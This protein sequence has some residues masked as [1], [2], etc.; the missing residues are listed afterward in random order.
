MAEVK[1]LV[2]GY[3]GKE[4]DGRTCPTITLIQDKGLNIIVDPGSVANQ[5][6]LIDSLEKIGLTVGDID[7][8][9]L[10]HSHIDHYMNVSLFTNAKY[11]EYFGWWEKD[12]LSLYESKVTEGIELIN[13][14]GHSYDSTTLLVKT[15]AGI[16][17]IC[18]DVFW[19]EDYPKHDRYATDKDA[20]KSS[21]EKVLR[22]TDY[23]IPGHGKMFKVN[24]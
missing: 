19:K 16:I 9:Y 24:K 10:T 4:K 1:I 6:I 15:K 7:I 5:K 12:R 3:C 17:A 8:V 22:M 23:I 21:R 20:L 14:P 13:T 2:E 18:G 11:L